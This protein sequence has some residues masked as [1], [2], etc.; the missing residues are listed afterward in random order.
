MKRTVT[1]SGQG[2]VKVA[3]DTAVVRVAASHRAADVAAALDGVT[4]ALDAMAAVAREHTDPERVSS[5]ELSVW[6]AYDDQGRPSGFEARHG[7]AIV[8]PDLAVAGRLIAGLAGAVGNRLNV[9]SVSLEV[10]DPAAARTAAREAAFADARD[11]AEH[12]AGLAGAVLG[13]VV[14]VAE[15]A[16]LP[17]GPLESGGA[18]VM[19]AA[20]KDVSFQPGQRSLASGVTVTWTLV[21]AHT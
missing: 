12:L 17:P 5:T 14:A 7:L 9:E 18:R 4:S 11:R 2:T 6:P 19:A 3:P 8:V 16:G 15:G 1:V 13:D 20:A 21:P 10:G